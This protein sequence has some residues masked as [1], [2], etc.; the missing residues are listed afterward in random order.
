MSH[1]GRLEGKVAIITGAG[2]GLGEGIARKFVFEGCKVLLF[3][4]RNRLVTI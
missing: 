4:R 1:Q 3:E 2:L